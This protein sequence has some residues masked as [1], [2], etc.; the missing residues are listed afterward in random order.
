ME[1]PFIGNPPDIVNMFYYDFNRSMIPCR[2]SLVYTAE[3]EP[4]L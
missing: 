1:I 2:S 3:L 4:K